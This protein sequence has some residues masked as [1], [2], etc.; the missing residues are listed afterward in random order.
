[1]KSLKK[2]KLTMQRNQLMARLMLVV[3]FAFLRFLI[4]IPCSLLVFVKQ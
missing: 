1:V 4:K 3:F 2:A